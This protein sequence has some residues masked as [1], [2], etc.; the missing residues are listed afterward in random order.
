MVSL[1]GSGINGILNSA[2]AGSK[3]KVTSVP[4]EDIVRNEQNEYSIEGIDSLAASIHDV[5][6]RQPIE[7]KSLPDGAYQLIG[8]ERRLT[9]MKKLLEEGDTRWQMVPCI[10]TNPLELDLPLTDELKE[11]YTL[12]ATNAE[13]RAKNDHDKMLDVQAMR[14]IYTA[15]KE[16][17]YPLADCQRSFIAESLNMSES[18]VQRLDYIAGHLSK[19]FKQL[20]ASDELPVTVATMISKLPE[21][22]QEALFQRWQADSATFN[23]GTVMTYLRE[24][25]KA[26]REA[27]PQETGTELMISEEFIAEIA[28]LANAMNA[29]LSRSDRKIRKAY[30]AKLL[31]LQKQVIVRLEEMKDIIDLG[32]VKR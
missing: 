17:G 21:A 1:N 19:R 28:R 4:M 31:R 12:T 13:Q 30:S 15:L 11:L 25:R 9:A 23:T 24:K 16:A 22:D 26:E 3:M 27:A 10:I 8:G 20:L 14:K 6:L 32:E 5:G 18:Q 29:T 7:V 2:S